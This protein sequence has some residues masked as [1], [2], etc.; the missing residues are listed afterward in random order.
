MVMS[1]LAC[2]DQQEHPMNARQAGRFRKA[3]V[4]FPKAKAS[5]A[6]SAGVFLGADYTHDI[7]RPGIEVI[8]PNPKT[9]GGARW[10]Y[11]AAWGWA[12]A[13]ARGCRCCCWLG[14]RPS[15][16]HCW[17]FERPSENSRWSGQ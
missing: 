4:L 1:H 14:N 12:L 16:Q 8:T 7:V 3:R 17:Q 2:A 13:F 11:L 10:A 15:S 6:N 5:L 9:S